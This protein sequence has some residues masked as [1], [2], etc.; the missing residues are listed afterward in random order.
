MMH[1]AYSHLPSIIHAL[2]DAARAEKVFIGVNARI[3]QLTVTDLHF[4]DDS[5]K[6]E[7][8]VEF[9]LLQGKEILL[10]PLEATRYYLHE[11]AREKLREGIPEIKIELDVAEIYSIKEVMNLNVSEPEEF[12][13][14]N[15]YNMNQKNLDYLKDNLKYNGFGESLYEALEKN[16]KEGKPEFVLDFKTEMNGRPFDAKLNF[17]KS[18]SSEMYF[19]NS[20]DAS[21]LRKDGQQLNQSF[22]I[23]KGKGVTAKEAFNLLHGRSV[24]KEMVNKAG[25]SYNAWLQMDLTNK[26]KPE[27]KI[28]H[29]NY[30]YNLKENLGRF[31]IK[32]LDGGQKEQDLIKSLERGN[33]QS[34]TM[35]LDG[36]ETKLFVEANPQF[37]TINVYDEKLKLLKHEELGIKVE[38]VQALVNGQSKGVAQKATT[39]QKKTT[40]LMPK[41]RVSKGVKNK[42]V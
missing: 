29:D 42:L 31:P 6:A 41:K 10:L 25:I 26:E 17:R 20:Y 35:N 22:F 11:A 37:K 27:M 4:F 15:E 36:K 1:I 39:V 19:F 5:R 38:P 14:Q 21:V 30:G 24:Y 16:I 33:T 3:Q 8:F 7:N 23:N 18:D 40:D 32:E 2:Q 13:N 9:N 12:L 28:Y 34:V